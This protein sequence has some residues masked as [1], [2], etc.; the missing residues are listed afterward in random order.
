MEMRQS[1]SE[2]LRGPV[3]SPG[4]RQFRDQLAS[5]RS[6]SLSGDYFWSRVRA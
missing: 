5:E 4:T 1:F 2:N 3:A 6:I